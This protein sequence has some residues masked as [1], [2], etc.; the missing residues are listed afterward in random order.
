M[1]SIIVINNLNGMSEV[2]FMDKISK[3]PGFNKGLWILYFN[4]CHNQLEGAFSYMGIDYPGAP[5][6][7][8][9]FDNIILDILQNGWD[10]IL[11]K[12]C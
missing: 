10:S 1:G 3:Y 6:G 12:G 9:D 2:D 8:F 5:N 7:R 11:G 4:D